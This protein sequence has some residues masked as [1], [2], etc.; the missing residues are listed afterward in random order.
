[1]EVVGT[2]TQAELETVH[3]LLTAAG[4]AYVRPAA[5]ATENLLAHSERPDGDS[6]GD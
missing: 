3:G 5:V 2:L 4:G 1:M 6:Q